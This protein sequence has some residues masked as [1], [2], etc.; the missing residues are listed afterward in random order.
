MENYIRILF[1]PTLL[2]QILTLNNNNL[3]KKKKIF[4]K[5][6]KGH[7]HPRYRAFFYVNLYPNFTLLTWEKHHLIEKIGGF[8]L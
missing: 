1:S 8:S 3:I 5:H 4:W 6:I 7:G 2:G